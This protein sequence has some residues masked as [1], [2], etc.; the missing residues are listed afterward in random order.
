MEFTN[1][2]WRFKIEGLAERVIKRGEIFIIEMLYLTK[3]REFDST[4][5]CW[6]KD[7]TKNDKTIFLC[8][9]EFNN[10][11]KDGSITIKH[12]QSY[13]S[14]LLWNGGINENL[15][16]TLRTSLYLVKAYDLTFENTWKFK[17]DVYGELLPPGSKVI[18]DI[19]YGSNTKSISCSSRDSYNIICDTGLSK[20]NIDLI[21]ISE[22]KINPSSVEWLGNNQ[23]DYLIFLN[24]EIDFI[25]VYN[26]IFIYQLNIWV[27]NIIVN[28]DIING[29]KLSVDI[30]YDN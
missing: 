26:L 5:K 20:K 4:A 7:G 13:E 9:M 29:S 10:Q 15:K 6:T 25:R 28:E 14:C 23:T 8:N 2:I 16:I 19:I 21:L 12:I 27:F 11:N 24:V 1:E 3:D 30:L 18:V 22:K 17:I